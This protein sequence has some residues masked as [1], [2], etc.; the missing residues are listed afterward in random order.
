MILLK[1]QKRNIQPF[2]GGE[3]VGQAIYA[4]YCSSSTSKFNTLEALDSAAEGSVGG[5]TSAAD[6]AI[7]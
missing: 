3:A 4:I 6:L 7:R 1:F 5:I 2:R